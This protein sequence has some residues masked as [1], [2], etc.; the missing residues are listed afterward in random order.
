MI[1]T[2]I[3]LFEALIPLVGAFVLLLIR[4]KII[5]LKKDQIANHNFL[6]NKVIF[7]Y[8]I[9]SILFFFAIYKSVMIFGGHN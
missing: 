1:Y 4:F 9:S 6:A 8:I 2:I 3:G 7:I 5:K